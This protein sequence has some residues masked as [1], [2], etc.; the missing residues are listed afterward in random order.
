MKSKVTYTH[1]GS[2]TT[3]G[4]FTYTLSDGANT[5]TGTVAIADTEQNNRPVA[6]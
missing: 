6:G 3:S 2:E 5:A 1:D 4:G